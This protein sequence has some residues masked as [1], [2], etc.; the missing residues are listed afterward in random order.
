MKAKKVYEM[1]DPYASEETDAMDLDV[2]YKKKLIE[3]WFAKW[4]PDA[5]Y[6]IDK[7]TGMI[8]VKNYVHIE[9]HSKTDKL[10]LLEDMVF[11]K[12]LWIEDI[13]F[14]TLPEYLSV[15]GTFDLYGTKIRK[16]DP[17]LSFLYK[18]GVD[19]IVNE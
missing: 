14:S 17:K 5:D 9:N 6:E 11:E 4:A 10:Y 18:L 15:K 7:V 8:Y 12:S 19:I 13:N 1:I 2:N 3:D 16:S